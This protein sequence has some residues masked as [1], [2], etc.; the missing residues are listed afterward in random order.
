MHLLSQVIGIQY[1]IGGSG[2]LPVYSTCCELVSIFFEQLLIPF[3][4]QL[5]KHRQVSG[6][7]AAVPAA[8]NEG[9]DSLM[10]DCRNKNA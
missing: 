2:T 3:F 10:A 8:A 7:E 6:T 4:Q 5:F 9:V 1:C